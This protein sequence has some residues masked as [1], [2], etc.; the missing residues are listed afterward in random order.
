VERIKASEAKDKQRQLSGQGKDKQ[1]QLGQDASLD[2]KKREVSTTNDLKSGRVDPVSPP[3][4]VSCGR[5]GTSAEKLSDASGTQAGKPAGT[6]VTLKSGMTDVSVSPRATVTGSVSDQINLGHS[7][8]AATFFEWHL[9]LGHTGK[10]ALKEFLQVSGIKYKGPEEF[11]CDGCG[12]G[13]LKNAARPGPSQNIATQPLER[14]CIDLS[15]RQRVKSLGGAEYFGVIVDQNTGYV[16]TVLVKTK[17]QFAD[18]FIAWA[19]QIQKSTGKKIKIVRGDNAGEH[20]KIFRYCKANNIEVETTV[21]GHSFQNGLA[22]RMIQELEAKARTL[23]LIAAAPKAFWGYAVWLAAK[24]YNVIGHRRNNWVGPAWLLLQES[25]R[26]DLIKPFGCI[27][28]VKTLDAGKMAAQGSIG[29]YM[30]PSVGKRAISVWLPGRHKVISTVDFKCDEKRFAWVEASRQGSLSHL[31]GDFLVKDQDEDDEEDEEQLAAPAR[32]AASIVVPQSSP[33]TQVQVPSQSQPSAASQLEEKKAE[34]LKVDSSSEFGVGDDRDPFGEVEESVVP[35]QSNTNAVRDSAPVVSQ[36]VQ[37]VV[38][39][40]EQPVPVS[41]PQPRYSFRSNRGVPAPRFDDD[42]K[43][44]V[45]TYCE[46]EEGK[47]FFI[48]LAQAQEIGEK[49]VPKT[50]QEAMASDEAASWAKAEAEEYKALKDMGS[51]VEGVPPPGTNILKSKMV[52][53]T[54]EN[55]RGEVERY[56][57]RLVA[58][59][60]G[61][62]FQEDYFFTKADV[63]PT[64]SF[65]FVMALAA[66]MNMHLTQLDVKSAFLN[67]KLDEEVWIKTPPG[68]KS[69]YWRLKKALY[70]LKQAAHNWRA[71]L[72]KILRELGLSPCNND[73]ACYVLKKGGELLVMAVHVD[74]MLVATKSTAQRDWIISKL[75]EKVTLKVELEP[76]WLLHMHIDYNREAGV[77]KLDQSAYLKDVLNKFEPAGHRTARTPLPGSTYLQPADHSDLDQQGIHLYQAIVG[78]LMY[79]ATHTRPDLSFSVG[80]LGK[81]LHAPAQEHLDAAYH[82]LW[83][84]RS[85]LDYCLV[86]NNRGVCNAV[87]DGWSDANFANEVDRHS[88]G[89]Y[90]FRLYGNLISW[91]SRRQKTVSVSTEEAEITAASEATREAYAL[92]G[93]CLA[94]GILPESSSITLYVDNNPAVTAIQNPGYYGRLKHLDIQQ[95]FVMEAQQQHIVSVKWCGTDTMLADS[96]TK[97][98]NGKRLEQ[99]YNTVMDSKQ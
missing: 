59:G 12:L 25:P 15:G 27:V 57:A 29:A 46:L 90:V 76:K 7:M 93:I 81:F 14:V 9:R 13:Q 87:L 1:R 86:Y 52:Y 51:Y 17:D 83:Y 36:P 68:C 95:K 40:Q 96:L 69:S 99:F 6:Q 28:Y 34:E 10:K 26:L 49:I 64:R 22:E 47:D 88:T 61:Q 72:D 85:T 53:A 74:D 54:K 58:C 82:V 44:N 98:S 20:E 42:P 39:Q 55:E 62:V 8:P 2:E 63:S 60:Y 16:K 97:P 33:P 65:R 84:V 80:H 66:S 78:S 4:P 73:P 79:A 71:L 70:G 18:E 89:S 48:K 21:A 50:H 11:C 77:L 23:L 41:Q 43:F 19:E 75:S 32:P 94:C 30:G 35:E 92:R 37:P 24:L 38:N 31:L 67:S 3:V 45:L 56:K 5:I 91:Q